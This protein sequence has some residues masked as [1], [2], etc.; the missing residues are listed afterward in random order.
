MSA[1]PRAWL[2]RRGWQGAEQFL[3]RPGG[4]LLA[5]LGLAALLLALGYEAADQGMGSQLRQA[6][7]ELAQ[8]S[9]RANR[10][11]QENQQTEARLASALAQLEARGG[12]GSP[13]ADGSLEGEGVRGRV[14]HRGETLVV[15]EGKL[16]LTLEA[17]LQNPRRALFRIQAMGQPAQEA[18]LA[19]GQEQRIKMTGQAQR[20]VLTGIHLSSVSLALHPGP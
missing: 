3:S 18:A 4:L 11:A 17:I 8:E 12:Q 9:S 10:L 20:L 7:K 6:R 16:S 13:P 15:L 2:A 14:L 5:T 19:P 1:G